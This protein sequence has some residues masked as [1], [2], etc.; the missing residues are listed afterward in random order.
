MVANKK[1]GEGKVLW[2]HREEKHWGKTS[3]RQETEKKK[4]EKWDCRLQGEPFQRCATLS[5]ATTYKVSPEVKRKGRLQVLA[6]A[7]AAP[8]VPMSTLASNAVQEKHIQ[9]GN[10]LMLRTQHPYYPRWR[11]R[12]YM[13]CFKPALAWSCGQD[14]HSWLVGVKS[15]PAEHLPVWLH[16][17][18]T[19][20]KFLK[21]TQQSEL[22]CGEGRTS[23][24]GSWT[25]PIR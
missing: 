2:K 15:T 18:G 20:L 4:D 3:D 21:I 5:W 17:K 23:K 14:T 10:K 6:S 7:L 11:G 8:F 9:R 1:W 19:Q 22:K 16:L 13:F 24:A 25:E 12:I